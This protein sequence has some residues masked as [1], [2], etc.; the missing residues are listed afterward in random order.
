G[1]DDGSGDLLALELTTV[2]NSGQNPA[3]DEDS[4]PPLAIF[5][6][7]GTI[8]LKSL[9]KSSNRRSTQRVCND[10][11]LRFGAHS[12]GLTSGKTVRNGPRGC[13]GFMVSGRAA[14]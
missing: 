13:Y 2:E 11:L 5:P 8:T 3:L 7:L 14:H 12:S 1:Q 4:N 10:L 6:L 9:G